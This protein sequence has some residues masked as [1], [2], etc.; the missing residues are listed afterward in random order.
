MF[1]ML[2]LPKRIYNESSIVTSKMRLSTSKYIVE[3]TSWE[4]NPGNAPKTRI[5]RFH[6]TRCMHQLGHERL[7]RGPR[8]LVAVA[9]QLDRPRPGYTN[10]DRGRQHPHQRFGTSS[11]SCQLLCSS[12][13]FYTRTHDS[14][15]AT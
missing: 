14:P 13:S 7:F 15:L 3:T 10:N 11:Y 1:C 9:S 2:H 6:P 8:L 12:T 5:R 4:E